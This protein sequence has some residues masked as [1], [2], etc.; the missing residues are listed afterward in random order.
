MSGEE[1]R[2]LVAQLKG[3]VAI[4]QIA[5]PDDR[6]ACHTP[7]K[8]SWPL[9]DGVVTS[10]LW[11]SGRCCWRQCRPLVR[12]GGST[13]CVGP[14]M[15]V[16]STRTN[17]DIAPCLCCRHPECPS[18]SSQTSWATQR[19]ARPRRSIATTFCLRQQAPWEPWTRCSATDRRS[20]ITLCVRRCPSLSTVG[21]SSWL[22]FGCSR[23]VDQ[24]FRGGP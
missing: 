5:D 6:K 8:R 9:L 10:W 3:I 24:H 22:Q 2:S 23:Q 21:C 19:R 7:P 16:T 4:L 17:C 15:S 13:A 14:P 11:D 12:R 18:S 20:P 1:I